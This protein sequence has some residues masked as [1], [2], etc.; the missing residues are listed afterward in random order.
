MKKLSPLMLALMLGL[1][2]AAPLQAAD[3]ET[4]PAANV[5][6]NDFATGKQ[7][8]QAKNW[9]AAIAAFQKVVARDP[10]NADAHNYLGY[11]YRWQGKMEES[12]KHY[13]QALQLDPKH[14]GAHEYIGVAYLK[15]NQPAKAREH[16]AQLEKIC[17]KD[18]DEYKDLSKAIAA[19]GK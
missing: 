13:N 3:T 15:T 10:K 12:F 4:T 6:N 7:A 16:L 8:I 2:L 18:C 9:G 5:Q 17:G 14:R 19:S 11:S 1:P